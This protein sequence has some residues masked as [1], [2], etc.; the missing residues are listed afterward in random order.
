[1]HGAVTPVVTPVSTR[2]HSHTHSHAHDSATTRPRLFAGPLTAALSVGRPP[3]S[4]ETPAA[5]CRSLACLACRAR[6]L[7]HLFLADVSVS[8]FAGSKEPGTVPRL[9]LDGVP[10]HFSPTRWPQWRGAMP[11][12]PLGASTSPM[13]GRSTQR[14]PAIPQKLIFLHLHERNRETE[15]GGVFANQ[16]ANSA[17]PIPP[18]AKSQEPP[19]SRPSPSHPLG[20]G[21]EGQEDKECQEGLRESGSLKPRQSG[22]QVAPPA[23]LKHESQTGRYQTASVNRRGEE[24]SQASHIVAVTEPFPASETRL[25]AIC[26]PLIMSTVRRRAAG[27]PQR[28]RNALRHKRRGWWHPSVSSREAHL[29]GIRQQGGGELPCT[30]HAGRLGCQGPQTCDG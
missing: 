27:L 8:G 24:C 20:Q 19:Q 11:I 6:R 9:Q 21:Q 13:R 5:A 2:A 23:R 12:G 29:H 16:I 15:G 17:L 14:N 1:M 25:V 26:R 3:P 10:L 4:V 22:K 28:P 18:R 7:P 30:Q